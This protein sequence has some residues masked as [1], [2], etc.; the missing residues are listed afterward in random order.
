MKLQ[1]L[2]TE[3]KEDPFR[4]AIKV[5][6]R[7]LADEVSLTDPIDDTEIGEMLGGRWIEMLRDEIYDALEDRKIADQAPELDPHGDGEWTGGK[8]QEET[9]THDYMQANPDPNKVT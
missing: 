6:A 9:I 5:I 2:I 8:E 7:T 4:D 3:S 1:A